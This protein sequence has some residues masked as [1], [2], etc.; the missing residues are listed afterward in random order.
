[1]IAS[2]FYLHGLAIS[3]EGLV[4]AFKRA[5]DPRIVT[6][7]LPPHSAREYSSNFAS[8]ICR[9]RYPLF[10]VIREKRAICDVV[11]G[12]SKSLKISDENARARRLCPTRAYAHAQSTRDIRATA[13]LNIYGVPPPPRRVQIPR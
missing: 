13:D 8:W 11:E 9:R 3:L 12:A 7:E 1:M 6:R 5:R 10:N 4:V 2:T